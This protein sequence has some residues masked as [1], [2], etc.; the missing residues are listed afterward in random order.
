[1]KKLTMKFGGTS[2]GDVSALSQAADIVTNE[3]K[4]WDQVVVVVSAM[5]GVTDDLLRAA[6]AAVKGDD[7]AH[8]RIRDSLLAKY[9]EVVGEMIEGEK[10]RG[11]VTAALETLMESL[12]QSCSKLVELGREEGRFMDAVVSLGER[13]SALLFAAI[14][15]GRGVKGEAIEA[16]GLVVTDDKFQNAAPHMDRTRRKVSARLGPLLASGIVP[17]VTGFIGA[18]EEGEITTLGRGGSDYS[19]AILG[20]CLDSDELWLWTD[21]DGVL[22]ADPR[23]VKNA[24]V[25][26]YLTYRE[27]AELA[28]FG[29][30][31]VHPKTIQPLS[32][33]GIPI[34]VKNTFAPDRPGSCIRKYAESTNGKIKGVSAIHNL[35]ILT[36][37]GRGMMGVPGI[38]A[39]TFSA[40]ASE[41]VSVL[42]ISQASSEQSICFVVPSETSS[43]VISAVEAEMESE[44]VRGDV[45]RI[46]S[47]DDVVIVTVVGV[48]IRE[49][50]GI[51]A[52]IFGAVG[53]ANINVIAIAQ[54]S[55]ECSLSIVVETADA[56]H[57]VR[58]IHHEVVNNA[59][60]AHSH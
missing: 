12:P 56:N 57:A 40:V 60:D 31:V 58:S 38:A 59:Q 10:E 30:K 27:V 43:S 42:M 20:A 9:N 14:L 32:D 7:Q 3:I 33:R 29:A 35:S 48:G 44:L 51:A 50:P 53:Q 28:Y 15:R 49:T 55:S 52:R 1:M 19:A 24:R 41:D 6:R 11:A 46:W 34:W 36:I 25:V 22:T 26:K 21:V 2:L 47:L 54:G 39:R 45:D 37:E 13:C 4:R 8:R 18:T 16:T 17:V 5:S 23:V